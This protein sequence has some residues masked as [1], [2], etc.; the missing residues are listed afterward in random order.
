VERDRV[1]RR[2]AERGG[3]RDG[4]VGDLDRLV[5][6]PEVGEREGLGRAPG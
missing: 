1:R 3:E 5:A 2:R 4:L 6:P